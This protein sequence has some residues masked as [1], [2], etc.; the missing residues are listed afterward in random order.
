MEI[1]YQ[2]HFVNDIDADLQH[3][4]EWYENHKKDLGTEFL[5]T[6]N[7]KTF[8][9][10]QFP[11]ASPLIWNGYHRKLM[12]HFPYAIYFMVENAT[13][14]ILGVFHT[15]RDPHFVETMIRGRQF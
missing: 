7:A 9:V 5:N 8:D 2:I 15:S 3:A 4:Y 6:F 13:V 10:K 12:I 1:T 14:I 11:E